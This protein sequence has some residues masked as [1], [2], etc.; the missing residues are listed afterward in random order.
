MI[1]ILIVLEATIYAIA[2][3]VLWNEYGV[4]AIRFDNLPNF[5]QVVGI[6]LVL[7]IL[8]R[9]QISRKIQEFNANSVSDFFGKLAARVAI[10][11]GLCLTAHVLFHVILK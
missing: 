8:T 6:L 11:L 1:G 2:I 7:F 4:A 5:H 3:G 10:I 9:G